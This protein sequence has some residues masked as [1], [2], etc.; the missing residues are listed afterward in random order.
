MYLGYRSHLERGSYGCR[1][2]KFFLNMA[3]CHSS[4]AIVVSYIMTSF[5]LRQQKGYVL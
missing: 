5:I 3:A 1:Q 2:E 4:W